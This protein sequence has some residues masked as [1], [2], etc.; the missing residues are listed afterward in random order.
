MFVAIDAEI[1]IGFCGTMATRARKVGRCKAEMGNELYVSVPDVGGYSPR[2][3]DVMVD[4][5][6][7][8]APTS[9]V[10]VFG[11]RLRDRDNNTGAEGREG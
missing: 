6:E 10:V 3:K 5:P 9:A 7:P 8:D 2:S 4:L 1:N 11:F